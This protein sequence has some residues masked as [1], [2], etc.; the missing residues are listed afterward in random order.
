[1]K[2]ACHDLSVARVPVSRVNGASTIPET[3]AISVEEPLEICVTAE[4]D[5]GYYPSTV[6][7]TM[8]TPGHD[9][10]LAAGLLF[11]EGILSDPRDVESVRNEGRNIVRL[12]TRPGAILEQAFMS[13]QSV[14]SSSCGACGKRYTGGDSGRNDRLHR[15]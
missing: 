4:S 12:K 10:E 11:T 5:E 8:R 3:D 15:P 2:N 6:A 7:V 14:V 1:M 13:R 9:D